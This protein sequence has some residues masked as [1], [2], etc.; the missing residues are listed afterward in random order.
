MVSYCTHTHT[1]TLSLSLLRVFVFAS[2]LQGEVKWNLEDDL[3]L[4]EILG[5]DES[6]EDEEEFN[7]EKLADGWPRWYGNII[8]KQYGIDILIFHSSA[9]N[10]YQLRSKWSAVK[11]SVPRYQFKT[12]QGNCDNMII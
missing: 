5:K 9:R 8:N 11:R 4:I 1:L 12:F 10:R 2:Q 7:W 3:K 6:I